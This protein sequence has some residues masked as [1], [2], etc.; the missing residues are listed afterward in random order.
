MH[1]I[2]YFA[3]LI[4]MFNNHSFLHHNWFTRSH[5]FTCNLILIFCCKSDSTNTR[6]FFSACLSFCWNQNFL[7]LA[8]MLSAIWSFHILGFECRKINTSKVYLISFSVKKATLESQM[9]IHL[10][11][12]KTPKHLRI[13]PIDHR[14]YWPLS[15]LTI[16]PIYHWA[17]QTSSLSTIESINHRVYQPLS[18]STIKPID[19]QA[20]WPS[21]QST[22]FS[23]NHLA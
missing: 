5:F 8:I 18:L 22:I 7:K 4:E 21:S 10:S 17:Y 2:I 3:T 23:I 20:Y 6:V 12:T 11:V 13:A 16:E 9:S 1:C 19:H 14:A 15:L